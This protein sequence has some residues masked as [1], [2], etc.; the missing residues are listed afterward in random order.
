MENTL[1]VALPM[2]NSIFMIGKV[3]NVLKL[4]TMVFIPGRPVWM[5]HGVHNHKSMAM[6]VL[7]VPILKEELLY[8]IN[9]I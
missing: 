3:Q 4:W 7:P 9:K 8:G 2:V 5:W 6:H 1:E